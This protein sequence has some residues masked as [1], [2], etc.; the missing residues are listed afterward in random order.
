MLKTARIE[1]KKLQKGEKERK[2]SNGDM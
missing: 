1:K 2:T